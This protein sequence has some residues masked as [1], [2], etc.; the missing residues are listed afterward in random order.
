M[1]NEAI[2]EVSVVETNEK[3]VSLDFWQMDNITKMEEY[4]IFM[5]GGWGETD[6]VTTGDSSWGG[7]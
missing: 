7:D 4:S 2:S 5:P 3:N 1:S 6:A